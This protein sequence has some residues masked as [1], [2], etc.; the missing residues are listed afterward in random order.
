MSTTTTTATKRARPH[1]RVAHTELT[2]FSRRSVY[3]DGGSDRIGD[4]AEQ[5]SGSFVARDRQGRPLGTFDSLAAAS[6][7]CWRAAHGQTG[8]VS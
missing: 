5:E 7:A 6:T 2:A 4:V 3:A 1:N 8:S